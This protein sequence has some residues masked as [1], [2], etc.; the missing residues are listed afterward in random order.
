MKKFFCI[1]LSALVLLLAGCGGA[2]A[3]APA[4]VGG[5]AEPDIAAEPADT[6]DALPESCRIYYDAAET[7]GAEDGGDFPL[8]PCAY[9]G[10]GEVYA[11]RM[12]D[13]SYTDLVTSQFGEGVTLEDFSGA[14]RSASPPP[15]RSRGTVRHTTPSPSPRITAP[16]LTSAR[17]RAAYCALR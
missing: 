8:S 9:E 15:T 13:G 3:P 12:P 7:G 17:T 10:V 5:D 4:A 1:F 11:V 16:S 6:E 2:D 14:G